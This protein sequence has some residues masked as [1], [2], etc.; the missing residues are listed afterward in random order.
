MKMASSTLGIVLLIFSWACVISPSGW[1]QA[2]NSHVLFI[3]SDEVALLYI[4]T[5]CLLRTYYVPDTFII[6]TYTTV[7]LLPLLSNPEFSGPKVSFSLLT[8][9]MRNTT[10]GTGIHNEYMSRFVQRQ[11]TGQACGVSHNQPRKRS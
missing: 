4:V 6:P 3:S 1:L 2:M 9:P 11:P 5:K 10:P 8:P 7:F